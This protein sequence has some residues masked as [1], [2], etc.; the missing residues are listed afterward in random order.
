MERTF[1]KG[2]T[3][4]T[5][6]EMK[7]FMKLKRLLKVDSR[8]SGCALM[9]NVQ[10]RGI[11]ARL[12][13]SCAGTHQMRLLG[14][15][16]GV[17]KGSDVIESIPEEEEE[18][19]PEPVAAAPAPP[20]ASSDLPMYYRDAISDDS[21]LEGVTTMA[22]LHERLQQLSAEIVDPG[23]SLPILLQTDKLCARWKCMEAA[24]L[25]W[26]TSIPCFRAT[27]D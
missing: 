15:K 24:H 9:C 1:T 10:S 4:I 21:N 16:Q 19:A 27:S 13:D 5:D 26:G 3:D 12:V 2:G 23:W 22:E 11:D 7:S 6:T 20:P 8:S 25:L 18:V 17:L 14:I